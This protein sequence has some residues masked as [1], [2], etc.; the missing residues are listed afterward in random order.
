MTEDLA[1]KGKGPDRPLVRSQ[2][3]HAS[4]G[5]IA[6]DAAGVSIAGGVLLPVKFDQAQLI[7]CGDTLAQIVEE[8]V[9]GRP[10]R[11]AS[12]IMIYPRGAAGLFGP[13]VRWLP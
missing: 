4:E 9:S 6:A 13:H 5:W 3:Q 1:D 8:F 2:V 12:G 7:M 10:G 11:E